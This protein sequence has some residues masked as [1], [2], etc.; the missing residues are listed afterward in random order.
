MFAWYIRNSGTE[1]NLLV[2]YSQIVQLECLRSGVWD[3]KNL[4]GRALR[5]RVDG[6]SLWNGAEAQRW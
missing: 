3:T 4:W 6:Q 5:A 1:A 2:D